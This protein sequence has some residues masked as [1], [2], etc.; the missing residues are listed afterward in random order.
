VGEYQEAVMT[1]QQALEAAD[2]CTENSVPKDFRQQIKQAKVCAKKSMES[3]V[4]TIID[5]MTDFPYLGGYIWMMR[6]TMW[7]IQWLEDL[8]FVLSPSPNARFTSTPTPWYNRPS[9]T[10]SVDTLP[11]SLVDLDKDQLVA[12]L[13]QMQLCELEMWDEDD[14]GLQGIE[15]KVTQHSETILT[16]LTEGSDS[17]EVAEDAC[18]GDY[19]P[20]IEAP[21]VCITVIGNI[22]GKLDVNWRSVWIEIGGIIVIA[23]MCVRAEFYDIYLPIFSRL[24]TSIQLEQ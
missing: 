24:L 22:E 3:Q 6:P 23:T 5:S 2:F 9:I 19:V 8:S 14:D 20:T 13:K 1:Y 7:D 11:S 12:A 21:A 10:L 4:Q 18:T 17:G 16:L 15:M